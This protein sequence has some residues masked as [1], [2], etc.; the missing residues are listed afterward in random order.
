MFG[1]DHPPTIGF[2]LAEMAQKAQEAAG[3]LS[4]SGVQPKLSVRLDKKNNLL[5][6]VAERGEYILKSQLSTYS[7]IP[8]NEQCCMDIA[9]E[10][11]IVVPPHCLLPLKDKSIAYIIKRFDREKGVK[12]HQEDFAQI[13]GEE[14]KY[15]GSV[16]QIG[17]KLKEI[18]TAP[19]Y[20]LQLF[21]ERIV[22]NFIIGNGDA[23]LK[24]YS[25]LYKSEE[26]RRLAPAYDLVCSK[27]VIP[28]EE[29]SALTIGGKKNRLT[30]DDFDR[31]AER[32]DIPMKVR[33]EKFENK[34]ALMKKIIA[35]SNVSRENQTKMI[36]IVKTCLER[37][38]LKE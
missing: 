19:G 30:R 14:N 38:G 18:S 23:H 7:H 24:N 11:G 13:L 25:M 9:Q 35:G 5:I 26:D 22:F 6:S 29:D 27:L 33:Y 32:F 4:I 34:L 20:D 28:R 16:E 10:L 31:L 2:S 8:E 12:I 1:V 3:K 36:D 37:L 17:H 15:G 21:F